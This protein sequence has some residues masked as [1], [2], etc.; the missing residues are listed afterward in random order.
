MAWPWG[1]SFTYTQLAEKFSWPTVILSLI[2]LPFS[3]LFRHLLAFPFFLNFWN[4]PFWMLYSQYNYEQ[5]DF[6]RK[7]VYGPA[8]PPFGKAVVGFKCMADMEGGKWFESFWGFMHVL[9]MEWDDDDLNGVIRGNSLSFFPC[10]LLVDVTEKPVRAHRL[11]F[12]FPIKGP[13][14]INPF[15]YLSLLGPFSALG[16]LASSKW[17]HGWLAK[18]GASVLNVNA[19]D[20]DKEGD[21]DAWRARIA[22]QTASST[23][24]SIS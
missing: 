3:F 15:M 21:A 11:R 6:I 14:A 7:N 17:F 5:D 10:E 16:Y 8:V 23:Y 1:G 19:P 22:L 4:K 18:N 13:F 20:V 12:N 24:G 2:L 9:D